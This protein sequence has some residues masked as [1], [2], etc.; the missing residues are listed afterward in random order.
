MPLTYD[1]AMTNPANAF[2]NEAVPVTTDAAIFPVNHPF[3]K[4]GFEVWGTH[5]ATGVHKKLD[6]M[7]DYTYSPPYISR[8]A[9][10]G[11]EIFTYVVLLHKS[12]W[13]GLTFNYHALGGDI[14]ATLLAEITAAGAFDRTS[15]VSWMRFVGEHASFRIAGI[16]PDLRHL[17]MLGTFNAK[18]QGIIDALG[19]PESYMDFILNDWQ[20]FLN[21]Y[22]ALVAHVDAQVTRL[23]L[24]LQD[25]T[26][27][28]KGI[29][30][31]ASPG[32]AYGLSNTDQALTPGVFRIIHIQ[33]PDPHLQYHTDARA[34]SKYLPL[35]PV[36]TVIA[37]LSNVPPIGFLECDGAEINR[38][39]YSALYGVIGA[40]TH[41]GNG[42]TT[43]NLPD[44]RGEFLRG[45]DHGRGADDGR[46][47]GSRQIGTAYIGSGAGQR[48]GIV[49]FGRW[50]EVNALGYDLDI[51]PQNGHPVHIFTTNGAVNGPFTAHGVHFSGVAVPNWDFAR[52]RPRN[53]SI[54]YCIKY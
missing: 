53:R 32:V 12:D 22:N 47:L 19:Q 34:D 13:S 50:W 2:T 16:D 45:W 30:Q 38:S 43:F 6:P 51:S 40:F 52:T 44:Y 33:H 29:I 5:I 42:T 17:G 35:M 15:P 54:M 11:C 49:N 26:Y 24:G 27:S 7:L 37:R 39:A 41:W 25:A 4:K 20:T 36:G 3:F 8:S 9:A 10:V 46:G 31:I 14:D 23:N 28:T 18:L 21:D 48:T 1:P